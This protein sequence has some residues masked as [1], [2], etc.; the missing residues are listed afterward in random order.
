MKHRVKV[1]Q[2]LRVEKSTIIEIEA[3]SIENAIEAISLGE[4][5]LPTA[6]H[7]PDS[8]WIVESSSVQNEAY[9]PS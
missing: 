6:S 8:V 2:V 1:T 7:D 3:N 9:L 4:I 5:D